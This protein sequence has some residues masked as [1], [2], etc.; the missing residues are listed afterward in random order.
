[1]FVVVPKAVACDDL[2]RPVLRTRN[3]RAAQRYAARHNVILAELRADGLIHTNTQ[4]RVVQTE[5]EA[6]RGSDLLRLPS[7]IL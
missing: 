7:V 6:L 4:Y 1:M 2:V 3:K 5:A